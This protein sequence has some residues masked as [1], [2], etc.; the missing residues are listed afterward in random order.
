MV[1]AL[2]HP[3]S[4]PLQVLL[5]RGT[6]G[7]L[8][9]AELLARFIKQDD[10]ESAFEALVIRHG[11]AVM[12]VC[13]NIL[14]DSHD[15]EDAFQATFLV[16]SRRANSLSCPQA[17]VGWL[18]GV[19]RR[20]AYKSRIADSRRRMHERRFAERARPTGDVRHCAADIL[21]SELSRLP[22][23]L[24]APVVLCYIDEMSYEAAARRLGVSEGT[25]RGR[26]AK[27]REM[28]RVRLAHQDEPP[29]AGNRHRRTIEFEPN[30]GALP[31]VLIAATTR[32]A[33]N[34]ATGTR[35]TMGASPAVRELTRGVLRMMLM[36]RLKLAT[37]VVAAFWLAAIV[38][39][40]AIP[41]KTA[42]PTPHEQSAAGAASAPVFVVSNDAASRT[43]LT[44]EEAIDRFLRENTQQ[45]TTRLEMTQADADRLASLLKSDQSTAATT[46]T[47][48][49]SRS[50][51]AHRRRASIELARPRRIAEAQYQDAV[52][53][54]IDS[55][56][57]SFVDLEAV[58]ERLRLASN[59]L[60]KWDRLFDSSQ[61]LV[62]NSI[63]PTADIDRI[64]SV[65]D[66]ARSKREDAMSSLS[67]ARAPL[68]SLLNLPT[69]ERQRLEVASRQ[70]QLRS[71]VLPDIDELI[72]LALASRP[73]LAAHRFGNTARRPIWPPRSSAGNR[74]PTFST[75]PT[76]SIVASLRACGVRLGPW[77]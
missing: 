77:E 5:E 57:K 65:R 56:Y 60:A 41:T 2:W 37:A 54:Q 13:R 3:I 8:S 27:A 72:P 22:E 69:I 28:L 46:Q 7:Q 51:L 12:Q 21:E 6:L 68:G 33:I 35:G 50:K 53:N 11:P 61:S 42:K 30:R 66:A 76:L 52:R 24:R 4:H 38:G 31:N 17:L 47:K 15:A 39:A 49:L 74:M 26:L 10:A 25:I 43:E 40:V 18:K 67:R 9:D 75:V 62:E 36:S 73:D 1:G 59:N 45:L 71:A 55:L 63:K 20:V 44:L 23:S 70:K 29:L 14:G 32:A 58:Q 64:R 34:L 16:L 19:A 48:S